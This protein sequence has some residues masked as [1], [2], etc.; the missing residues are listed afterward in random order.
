MSSLNGKAS[1]LAPGSKFEADIY[2]FPEGQYLPYKQLKRK[3]EELSARSPPLCC[4][5]LPCVA[6]ALFCDGAM[7]LVDM[8]VAVLDSSPQAR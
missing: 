8:R 4:L 3:L 7:Q 6:Q 2:P 5:E 1:E